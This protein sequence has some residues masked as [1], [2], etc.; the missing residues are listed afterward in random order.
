[1][2][3]GMCALLVI[4]CPN[5]LVNYFVDVRW[6]LVTLIDDSRP[7]RKNATYVLLG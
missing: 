7:G 3:L 5:L 1:M 6:Q 2:Y 4:V